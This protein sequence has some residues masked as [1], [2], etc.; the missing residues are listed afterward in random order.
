M[1]NRTVHVPRSCAR[2]R[3][4][5]RLLA[6]LLVVP[7]VLPG[8]RILLAQAQTPSL[9]LTGIDTAQFPDVS[10][11]VHGEGLDDGLA[12]TALTLFEDGVEVQVTEDQTSTV[13]VQVMVVLD[14]WEG[15]NRNGLTGKP[16]RDEGMIG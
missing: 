14:A 16:Q 1:R 13:G 12:S 3:L 9:T 5:L 2:R 11:T 10:A 15:I 8:A 4:V 6:I 7:T